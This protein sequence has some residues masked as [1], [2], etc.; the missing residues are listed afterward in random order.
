MTPFPGPFLFDFEVASTEDLAYIPMAVRFNLDRAGLRIS[1]AQWQALSQDTR[2]ALASIV[3][4]AAD[5]ADSDAFTLALDTAMQETG[6][7]PEHFSPDPTPSW[8]QVGPTPEPVLRQIH[9]AGLAEPRQ[10]A[11][12]SLA[13]L[14]RYVLLKLSRKPEANHDFAAACREFGLAR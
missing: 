6:A 9:L 10:E 1:L 5:E 7:E 11:W 14:L 8:R 12:S 3:P 13:P 4:D 2:V